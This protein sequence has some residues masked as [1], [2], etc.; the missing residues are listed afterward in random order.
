M[1]IGQAR[2]LSISMGVGDKIDYQIFPAHIRHQSLATTRIPRRPLF[3]LQSPIAPPVYLGNTHIYST[4]V[5]TASMDTQS[6][7]HDP[8]TGIISA[9]LSNKSGLHT[10]I[11]SITD[12]ISTLYTSAN[13][14]SLSLSA[15]TKGKKKKKGNLL[16]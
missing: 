3:L 11:R 12:P 13:G 15:T 8:L 7:P 6:H 14:T 4:I 9:Y 1:Y 2:H 10:T 5:S 16:N